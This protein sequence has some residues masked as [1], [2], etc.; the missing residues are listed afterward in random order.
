MEL[1]YIGAVA[2]I[3]WVIYNFLDL[4]S[5]G[6]DA[7]QDVSAS[8]ATEEGES[9]Q[10]A[11]KLETPVYWLLLDAVQAEMAA[12][13]DANVD[14]LTGQAKAE[15]L[16]PV[17]E[18]SVDNVS[19]TQGVALS[20]NARKAVVNGVLDEIAGLGPLEKLVRQK[21]IRLIQVRGSHDVKVTVNDQQFPTDCQF[22]DD[23]HVLTII[24]R[25]LEPQGKV[26]TPAT[27]AL[28]VK[29][30]D[31]SS[32]VASVP[33]ASPVPYTSIKKIAS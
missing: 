14:N 18:R 2:V 7:P 8:A 3:G 9:S 30:P 15:S 10:A 11:S 31:G 5:L 25:V 17:A 1:I 6:A 22:R 32:F 27:P 4:S 26:L 23:N 16:R 12:S 24:T 21:R 28:Q 19:I 13:V 33:P 20:P 29:L